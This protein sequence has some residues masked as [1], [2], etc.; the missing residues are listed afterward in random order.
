[1][2]SIETF[3]E[4]HVDIYPHYFLLENFSRKRKKTEF[5]LKI[6]SLL[7]KNRGNF[8]FFW[9]VIRKL[10]TLRRKQNWSQ[11][12]IGQMTKQIA[13]LF[14]GKVKNFYAKRKQRK[15]SN[16]WVVL[17]FDQIARNFDKWN[18]E[19]KSQ[20]CGCSSTRHQSEKSQICW[21]FLGKVKIFYAKKNRGNRVTF[22]LFWVLMRKLETLIGE[23]TKTNCRFVGFL[24]FVIDHKNHRFVFFFSR[25][26]ETFYA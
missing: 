9:V 7:N 24:R 16:I 1:M 23:T 21:F 11:A 12:L 26:S 22:G 18:D 25:E 3:R 2:Q 5:L 6:R 10:I 20:I 14:L 8:G 4:S 15:Q 17:G 19:T 13:D